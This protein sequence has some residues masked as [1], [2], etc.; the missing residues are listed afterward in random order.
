LVRREIRKST[1]SLDWAPPTEIIGSKSTTSDRDTTTSESAHERNSQVRPHAWTELEGVLP[2]LSR[3]EQETL[4]TS[5]LAHGVQEP[6][7]ILPDGRIIDGLHRWK[8]SNEKAPVRLLQIDAQAGFELGLQLNLQRRHLSPE[9]KLE[10]CEE[11]RR[12][13][14]T[15]AD[16]HRFTGFSTGSISQILNVDGLK[17]SES[18]NFGNENTLL[19]DLRVHV[20]KSEYSKIWERSKNE[21]QTRIAGDYK[22]TK[23]R[24]SQILTYYGK[25][26]DRRANLE[27]LARR[28]KDT[29]PIVGEYSTIVVDPAWPVG[30][31]YDPENWRGASPYPEMN[32]KEI[33]KLRIPAAKDATLW[34][35]APNSHLHDAFHILE[36]WGFRYRNLLTWAKPSIGLGRTL[37]GQTEHALLGTIGSPRLKTNGQSTLLQA[38]RREHSRKPD[39]FYRLVEQICEGPRLDYFGRE[40]RPGW[41]VY[42]GTSVEQVRTG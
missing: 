42:N 39:E 28:A 36:G 9:Q 32:L 18:S 8:L 12:R 23:Q 13:R 10:V 41:T 1:D 2:P 35:W 26:L 33:Q 40:S 6:V 14:Y 21:S 30:S 25:E 19:I 17:K 11:L 16:I 31:K 37:R 27:E 5:I 38:R 15:Y 29:P 20:P 22:I 24:I 3:L 7:K 4:R 34:L